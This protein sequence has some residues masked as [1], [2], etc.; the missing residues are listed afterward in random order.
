MAAKKR[1]PPLPDAIVVA[2]QAFADKVD[3]EGLNYALEEYGNDL[4]AADPEFAAIQARFC[5][6]TRDARAYMRQ[7]CGCDYD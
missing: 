4:A 6:A 2:R 7:H 1:I 3:T 5:E